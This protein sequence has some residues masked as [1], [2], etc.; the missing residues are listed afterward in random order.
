M[1]DPAG[2]P[3]VRLGR[4]TGLAVADLDPRLMAAT[5]A[6]HTMHADRIADQGGRHRGSG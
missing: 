1:Y 6:V 4:E 2:R 5:R 3:L